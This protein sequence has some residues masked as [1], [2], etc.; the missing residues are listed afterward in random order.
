MFE[1]F[2]HFLAFFG[3]CLKVLSGLFSRQGEAGPQQAGV[4]CSEGKIMTSRICLSLRY[5]TEKYG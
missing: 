3:G 2:G 5:F 4:F 1:G